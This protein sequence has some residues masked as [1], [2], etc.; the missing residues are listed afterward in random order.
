MNWTGGRLRRQSHNRPGSLSTIQKQYFAKA[1]LRL[2]DASNR[3]VASHIVP[4]FE[5]NYRISG[6]TDRNL[7]RPHTSPVSNEGDRENELRSEQTQKVCSHG[8]EPSQ[9]Q[10]SLSQELRSSRISH[11]SI[12]GPP[13]SKLPHTES[14]V[15]LL[16]Y[17]D[18]KDLADCNII[19]EGHP[20]SLSNLK[21][22][23]YQASS[24]PSTRLG[25]NLCYTTLT[26]EI[27]VS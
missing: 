24:S 20:E 26:D 22:G 19:P 13:Y 17:D 23:Q 8:L 21:I 16:A 4:F 2:R 12:S 7:I 11:E 18:F 14:L 3:V 10:L 15:I 1:R 5:H 25:R 9:R 6:V 27:S